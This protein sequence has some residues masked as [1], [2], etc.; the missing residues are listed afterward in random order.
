MKKRNLIF[1]G[2]FLINAVYTPVIYKQKIKKTK[3]NRSKWR[4]YLY[5]QCWINGIDY[6]ILKAQANWESYGDPHQKEWSPKYRKYISYGLFQISYD[7]A[8]CYFRTNNINPYTGRLDDYLYYYKNN[9]D[10]IIW[11]YRD[12][13]GHHNSYLRALSEHNLGQAGY[14][15]WARDWRRQKNGKWVK[16]YKRYIKGIEKELNRKIYK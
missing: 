15:R 3:F 6:N 10:I 13:L 1:L 12:R 8:R 4:V 14:G 11:F 7:T 16:Y 2:L 5:A 9:I